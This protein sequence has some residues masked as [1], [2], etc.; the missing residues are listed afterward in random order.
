MP[1]LPF[2][3]RFIARASGLQ[4]SITSQCKL[5]RWS[6]GKGKQRKHG[7]GWFLRWKPEHRK[8]DMTSPSNMSFLNW[9]AHIRRQHIFP[10]LL[11]YKPDNIN[12]RTKTIQLSDQEPSISLL[13]PSGGAQS[14]SSSS[15]ISCLMIWGGAD[16]IIIEI[17]CTVKVMCLN[18][19]ETTP[20]PSPWNNCLLGN[21]SLVPKR[22][23]TAALGY[24]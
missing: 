2:K 19:P 16:T 6:L 22:L 23:G 5:S 18:H 14:F 3:K 10:M 9:F 4:A 17:Q 24:L 12:L 13:R 15:R 21:Q 7:K 8:S 20:Q 11:H 1:P